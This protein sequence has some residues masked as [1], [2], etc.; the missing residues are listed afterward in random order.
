MINIRWNK[1]DVN[2][3]YNRTLLF[4]MRMCTRVCVCVF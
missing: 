3:T 4:C 2:D 1:M